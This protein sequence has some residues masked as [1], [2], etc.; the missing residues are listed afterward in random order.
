MRQL[1]TWLERPVRTDGNV[2]PIQSGSSPPFFKLCY[3]KVRLFI[4]SF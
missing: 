2:V 4:S 1:K 3:E